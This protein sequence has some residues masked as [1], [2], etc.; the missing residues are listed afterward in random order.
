MSD[1]GSYTRITELH[2]TTVGL[3]KELEARLEP[4]LVPDSGQETPGP[5]PVSGAPMDSFAGGLAEL[6]E[7]IRN[8]LDRLVI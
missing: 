3:V 4:V 1:H 6:N 5:V 7:H 8:M 2:D